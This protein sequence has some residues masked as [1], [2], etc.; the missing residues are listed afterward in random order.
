MSDV[1]RLCLAIL[2][3]GLLLGVVASITFYTFIVFLKF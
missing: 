3:G 1:D 2:V